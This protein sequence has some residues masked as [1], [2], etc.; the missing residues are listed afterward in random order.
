MIIVLKPNSPAEEIEYISQELSNWN[1]RLEK[2]VGKHKLII[3]LIGDTAEIAPKQIQNLSQ[4]IEQVLRVEK[5][6]K[7]QV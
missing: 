1:V 2:S 7:E 6:L 3:G 4:C 5:P